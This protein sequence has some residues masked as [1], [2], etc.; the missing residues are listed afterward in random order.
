MRRLVVLVLVGLVCVAKAEEKGERQAILFLGDSLTAGYGLDESR[1]FPA[2]VQAKIAAGEL[3]R[4]EP[5]ILVGL[6]GRRARPYRARRLEG[7]GGLV[8]FRA[9]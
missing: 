6:C 5:R 4:E 8:P 3:T 1:A 2:F 9:P 7:F